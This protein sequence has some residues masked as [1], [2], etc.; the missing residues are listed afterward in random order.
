MFVFVGGDQGAEGC[1]GGSPP[2]EEEDDSAAEGDLR[3][4][5]LYSIL[6]G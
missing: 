1:A 4:A 5:T 2:G 3:D 6:P